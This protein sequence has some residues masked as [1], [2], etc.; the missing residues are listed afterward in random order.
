M[1][2][3]LSGADPSLVETATFALLRAESLSSSRIEGLSISH[4]RLAEALY[5]PAHAKRLASEVA[6]NVTALRAAIALGVDSHPITSADVQALHARPMKSV[7]GVHP[8]QVRDVQNWIGP[9]GSPFDAVYVPPPATE[10][11]RLMEDLVRFINRNDLPPVLHAAIAHGQFEAIHPFVDG[12]GRVGRCLTSIILRRHSCTNVIPPVSGVLL[13]NVSRYY[14]AL[15]AFQQDAKPWPWVEQFSH[16]IVASCESTEDLTAA[17]GRLTASWMQRAG[18]P[19]RGSITARLVEALPTL[20]FTDAAQVAEQLSVDPNVAR[21]GL[22]T[23][24]PRPAFSPK[25]PDRSGTAS[26]EPTSCTNSST[27]SPLPPPTKTLGRFVRTQRSLW[28]MT[29][30]TSYFAVSAGPMPQRERI[31][32][33]ECEIT[34]DRR[35][36]LASGTAVTGSSRTGDGRDG[37]Q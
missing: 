8:G 35:C 21:R 31:Q 3:R 23:R 34:G 13:R 26:G 17:L 4:R 10:V 5:D 22:E 11:S 37:R 29:L 12:N 1:D 18:N 19:R 28:S 7:P 33:V 15:A 16:A 20:S 9:S 14:E 24:P 32:S 30:R 2:T 6:N 36:S 27:C 25:W